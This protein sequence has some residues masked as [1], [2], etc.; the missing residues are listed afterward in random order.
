[1][2]I[3]AGHRESAVMRARI[4]SLTSLDRRQ[5]GRMSAHGMV[6]HLTDAFRMA[7]GE[8]ATSE[9]TGLFHRT[10]LKWGALRVPIAWP[11]DYPTRPELEQGKGGSCPTEFEF[12]R[13]E[14]LQWMERFVATP[15]DR[16]ARHP[17]F[18]RM[19]EFEWRRWGY[20]HTD[21]HLRQFGR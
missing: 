10:I 4:E 18:G 3:L 1:M 19:S 7:L 20:L 16:M 14:L 5:W 9:A 2:R 11:K 13:R 15:T 21:H 12:D 8:R 6:C 17:I